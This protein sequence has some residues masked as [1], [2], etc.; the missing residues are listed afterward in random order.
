[1]NIKMRKMFIIST[2]VIACA[3]S[4]CGQGNQSA[5]V[6]NTNPQSR[7]EI[8]INDTGAMPENLTSSRDGTIF[9]GSTS[10][11]NI[12]R[13]LPGA[14]QAEVWIQ[15]STN[16]LT[17]VYGVLA[18][19]KSNTLWVC[20]NAARGRGASGGQTA[21]CSFDLKTG[22]AKGTYPFPG[23]GTAND[24]A[25]AAEGSVYTSDTSGGRVLRLKP[26]ATELDVWAADA[27]LRGIDG[28]SFLADGALYVNSYFSGSFLRIP[29]NTDGTAGTI[30]PIETTL[31]FSRPDGLR[32]SGTNTL[33]QVEGQGRLTEITIEGNRGLVRVI[34]EGMPAATGVTQIGGTAV[35]LVQ[36]LKGIVVPMDSIPSQ[37]PASTEVRQGTRPD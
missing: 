5:A 33:L 17:S 20:V 1:M 32:T 26:G 16:G 27:Q 6:G 4:V 28:L 21:L 8:T 7:T 34:K 37:T 9:F 2:L 31:R 13:A 3:K 22:A 23:G 11:G 19:D 36:Q 35:V 25:V 14:A 15:G 18:D 29:V 30:V 10:K 24:I 12:Y